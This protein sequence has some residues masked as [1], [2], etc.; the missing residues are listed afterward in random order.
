MERNETS[1]RTASCVTHNYASSP[2]SFPGNNFFDSSWRIKMVSLLHFVTLRDI[3]SA[4]SYGFARRDLSIMLI[5]VL[6][7]TQF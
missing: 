4:P 5:P 7:R 1:G 3:K 6:S 2:P